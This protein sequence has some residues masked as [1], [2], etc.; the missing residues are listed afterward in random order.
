[1]VTVSTKNIS[2][3]H[4]I[5]TQRAKTLAD[6][7]AVNNSKFTAHAIMNFIAMAKQQAR[8]QQEIDEA[9]VIIYA[10]FMR[11]YPPDIAS[12]AYRQVH[13]FLLSADNACTTSHFLAQ[14]QLIDEEEKKIASE[15]LTIFYQ[16]LT[17]GIQQ[18]EAELSKLEHAQIKV[19]RNNN[20]SQEIAK[21]EQKQR[22]L[23]YSYQHVH[24]LYSEGNISDKR[25]EIKSELD[26]INAQLDAARVKAATA[27]TPLDKKVSAMHTVIYEL[28]IQVQEIQS[29]LSNPEQVSIYEIENQQRLFDSRIS[30]AHQVVEHHQ[31]NYKN[32]LNYIFAKIIS[33]LQIARDKFN[34]KVRKEEQRNGVVDLKTTN[35][36]FQNN[37]ARELRRVSK[38]MNQL[39]LHPGPVTTNAIS[40]KG[41]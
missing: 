28:K 18:L 32:T 22:L 33:P 13:D 20:N 41:G 8:T 34:E 25:R 3:H 2:E 38:N 31:D 40:A 15:G 21:L 27:R 29:I 17:A 37:T 35:L 30:H 1:M 36:L 7:Y 5:I 26:K 23:A 24:S 16:Q 39:D 11:I 12:E 9:E 4:E 10:C 6:E 19:I 14:L